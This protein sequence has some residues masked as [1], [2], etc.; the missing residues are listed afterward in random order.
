MIKTVTDNN[1]LNDF[2][3]DYNY[4]SWFNN[5]SSCLKKDK[6]ED[7][8]KKSLN[9][10]DCSNCI[11]LFRDELRNISN[12]R[13]D[14][15]EFYEN[16][17]RDYAYIWCGTPEIANN[18]MSAVTDNTFY[19]YFK[20]KYIGHKHIKGQEGYKSPNNLIFDFDFDSFN[21][22]TGI[23]EDMYKYETAYRHYFM[24]VY[25]LNIMQES[26]INLNELEQD[27]YRKLFPTLSN[28]I[29][30][31]VVTGMEAFTEFD[32]GYPYVLLF[33]ELQKLTPESKHKFSYTITPEN[34]SITYK[35]KE[36]SIVTR[37][38]AKYLGN[39]PTEDDIGKVIKCALRPKGNYKLKYSDVILINRNKELDTATHSELRI[40]KGSTLNRMKVFIRLSGQRIINRLL[41]VNGDVRRNMKTHKL[42][43]YTYMSDN[44]VAFTLWIFL[45]STAE[46]KNHFKDV[47][48]S[49][50]LPHILFIHEYVEQKQ[51]EIFARASKGTPRDIIPNT[52]TVIMLSKLPKIERDVFIK[53]YFKD[54]DTK[55][56]TFI[57]QGIEKIKHIRN[58]I[59]RRRPLVADLV[60]DLKNGY[61]W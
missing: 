60:K 61:K 24:L 21:K 44:F 13:I 14:D 15:I 5:I 58:R 31:T 51:R 50:L 12:Y 28:N 55:Q 7:I 45:N 48:L 11:R 54:T 9:K 2:N 20:V 8:F 3:K 29:N 4:V 19:K 42:Q 37:K 6:L 16:I 35:I 38:F 18:F 27:F 30:S 22:L 17:V 33:D 23:I 46:S 47:K 41:S 36:Y 52:A 34:L 10:Q 26:G 59:R 32:L 40:V 25:I 56:K 57:R 53:N 39:A 1:L 43:E 49:R